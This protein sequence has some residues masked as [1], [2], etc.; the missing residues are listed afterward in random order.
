MYFITY[1]AFSSYAIF[2][3]IPAFALMVLFTV[4]TVAESLRYN[5]VIIAHI[6]LVGAYAVPFLLSDGSG[7][8]Y[9]LF[10]YMAI[11]NAGILF[12]AFKRYW[13]SLWYSS[14]AFTI[15][16][17]FGWLIHRAIPDTTYYGLIYFPLFFAIHLGVYLA[18]KLYR[19]IPYTTKDHWILYLNSGL[20][21]IAI[22]FVADEYKHGP[23]LLTLAWIVIHACIGY[24][25]YRKEQYKELAH[26]FFGMAFAF[27]AVL[28]TVQWDDE[29]T[30]IGWALQALMLAA[31]ASRTGH[32]VYRNLFQGIMILTMGSMLYDWSVYYSNSWTGQASRLFPAVTNV[33][34][35]AN[36]MSTLLVLASTTIIFKNEALRNTHT[37]WKHVVLIISTGLAAVISVYGTFY[38]EILHYWSKMIYGDNWSY[39]ETGNYASI[40]Q[41]LI[42]YREVWL[43]NY[44]LIF[45][46]VLSWL[47]HRW[48][49]N[50]LVLQ[51]SFIFNLIVLVSFLFVGLYHLSNLRLDYM[52]QVPYSSHWNLTLRYVSYALIAL[53]LWSTHR[54]AV[55]AFDKNGRKVFDFALHITCLW[56]LSSEL[57]HWRE[58]NN[59][60][61][62][63]KT[64][65]SILWGAYSLFLIAIGIIQKKSYLRIAAL[66][67]LGVTLIKLFFYDLSELNTLSKTIVMV[68]LG[69]VLLIISFLYNKYKTKIF[70]DE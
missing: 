37:S 24:G 51:V 25:L 69:V 7:K 35:T 47:L 6:G 2:G 26:Q 68:I 61:A 48:N 53:A 20:Y 65:L 56:L 70:V 14:I 31:L 21:F 17:C 60:A 19:E 52:N 29:W 58:L 9:I 3:R 62:A 11:I 23:L 43:L 16:I 34:F 12:I 40:N 36:L 44:S 33:H 49:A 45:A 57:L 50:R 8:A 10:T 27:L 66:V 28:V 64:G 32:A 55:S 41:M 18:F 38:N 30:T 22:M 5:R 1:F 54:I 4:V 67:W 13:K 63:D 39:S 42:H 46:A 59:S 15:L